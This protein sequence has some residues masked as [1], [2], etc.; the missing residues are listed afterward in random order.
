[1]KE[2]RFH[3][4]H[5][6][7]SYIGMIVTKVYRD[8]RVPFQ[9]KNDVVYSIVNKLMALNKEINSLYIYR[10]IESGTMAYLK[11]GYRHIYTDTLKEINYESLWDHVCIE[12]DI[13]LKALLEDKDCIQL[14]EILRQENISEYA[15][16]EGISRQAV[17]KRKNKLIEKLRK[18]YRSKDV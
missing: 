5:D 14:L 15:R 16:K 12:D 18:K 7:E 8:Q 17:Y 9:D 3:S 10:T 13:D 11:N 4:L 2:N 1:M 6:I